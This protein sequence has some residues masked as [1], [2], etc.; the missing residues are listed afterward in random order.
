[1]PQ[2]TIDI[3]HIAVRMT[4][5]SNYTGLLCWAQVKNQS[6]IDLFGDELRF[7]KWL[8]WAL[9]VT[10]GLFHGKGPFWNEYHI[11]TF[12]ITNK[13]KYLKGYFFTFSSCIYSKK[14]EKGRR[15]H[16]GD[17]WYITYLVKQIVAYFTFTAE[18]VRVYSSLKETRCYFK[19]PASILKKDNLPNY[20]VV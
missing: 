16:W 14:G 6:I 17:N 12:H 18:A 19:R 1:M 15:W 20:C 4:V 8:F 13:L 7:W 2:K 9:G 11:F 3:C 10:V 5:G